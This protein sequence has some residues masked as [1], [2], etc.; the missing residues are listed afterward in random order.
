MDSINQQQA[1]DNF[2][3]LEGQEAVAKLKELVEKAETCFFCSDIKTG[4]P[5][6]TR[7]MAAQ[8]V[9][10]EGNIWFLSSNDSN[11]NA[12]INADPFVQLL[13]QGRKHSAFLS[14]YGISEIS[15]DRT[16]ID[17]LWDPIM[18]TWFQGGKDDPRIS[19]LKVIPHQSYYWDTKHGEA[20]SFLKMAASVVSGKT[21]DDSIEGNLEV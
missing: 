5:F 21:M 9:D 19:I 11:K 13:F 3:S 15:E 8:K 17:E 12:E 20:V 16:K 18:K 6:S 4:L 2:K 7:P 14:V 10:E 1:E